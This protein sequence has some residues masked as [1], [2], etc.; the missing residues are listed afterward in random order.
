MFAYYQRLVEE[1]F[2]Q[3][4]PWKWMRDGT[5]PGVPEPH[6]IDFAEG[7]ET[8]RYIDNAGNF[9]DQFAIEFYR[10]AAMGLP[11]HGLQMGNIDRFR[12]GNPDNNVPTYACDDVG[13]TETERER[14]RFIMEATYDETKESPGLFFGGD[15]EG[16]EQGIPYL[17]G[18]GFDVLWMSPLWEN[19]VGYV[20]YYNDAG[21]QVRA[22]GPHGYWGRNFGWLDP[23]YGSGVSRAKDE[24]LFIQTMSAL[25]AAGMTVQV[26]L[27]MNHAG[28]LGTNCGLEQT[29]NIIE[30]AAT[31]EV[32]ERCGPVGDENF[33]D[34]PEVYEAYRKEC[35]DVMDGGKVFFRDQLVFDYW[36]EH[37]KLGLE[38]TEVNG[39]PFASGF[40]RAAFHHT[41][42]IKH[43]GF[44][45]LDRCAH[46]RKLETQSLMGLVDL[47]VYGNSKAYDLILRTADRWAEHAG[48]ARFDTLLYVLNPEEC[49]RYPQYWENV[50]FNSAGRMRAAKDGYSPIVGEWFDLLHPMDMFDAGMHAYLGG[51][52]DVEK[53][54]DLFDF[55]FMHSVRT[56]FGG[57]DR[58]LEAMHKHLDRL[59]HYPLSW[60]QQLCPITSN[61]DVPL[62]LNGGGWPSD[63]EHEQAVISS[64]ILPGMPYVYAPDLQRKIDA[65]WHSGLFGRGGDPYNRPMLDIPTDGTQ[66][67][68]MERLGVRLNAMTRNNMLALRYG[69][70]ETEGDE[71]RLVIHRSFRDIDEMLYVH[72][73]PEGDAIDED[74]D[75]VLSELKVKFPAGFYEDPIT[76]IN[77]QVTDEG[78]IKPVPGTYFDP[79]WERYM[80]VGANGRITFPDQVWTNSATGI[81]YQIENGTAAIPQGE[82]LPHA[83]DPKRMTS[84]RVKKVKGALYPAD[85][86]Y[87]LRNAGKEEEIIDIRDG[88][89][90][91]KPEWRTVILERRGSDEAGIP[92][93]YLGV[94]QKRRSL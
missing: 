7:T 91:I 94:S 5:H 31:P 10:I 48:G 82:L 55:G 65:G 54:V 15:L 8:S 86:R 89:V 85:G 9:T 18:L 88:R 45:P 87:R 3:S 78:H 14:C 79:V 42:Y 44:F 76:T 75:S 61:H 4:V 16:V 28:R 20:T 72:V 25:R 38:K 19:T 39:D 74:A 32:L 53:M 71:N 23:H 2:G 46:W 57:R 77:Y 58:S 21:E 27:I 51:Q 80:E 49:N 40:D 70:M 24:E 63:V 69:T 93:D 50:I 1:K 59:S 22:S 12:D 41:R 83:P 30:K 47:N 73:R 6:E 13:T 62:F 64:Y 34:C 43:W 92:A 29:L 67:Y 81:T 36:K 33:R 11:A 56:S 26:D 68:P 60:Q 37:E 90:L 66:R 84:E 52:T 17:Q 35:G